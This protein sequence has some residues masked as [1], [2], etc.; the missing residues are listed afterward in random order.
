MSFRD[1]LINCGYL[2]QEVV[3]PLCGLLSKYSVEVTG[4]VVTL[5]KAGFSYGADDYNQCLNDV[6]LKYDKLMSDVSEDYAK[7]RDEEV[8]K[9]LEGYFDSKEYTKSSGEELGCPFD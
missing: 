1:S 4:M 2:P 8:N 3:D 7:A 6:W 5:N 9:S